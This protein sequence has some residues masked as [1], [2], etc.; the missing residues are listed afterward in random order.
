MACRRTDTYTCSSYVAAKSKEFDLTRF[1]ALRLYKRK[2]RYFFLFKNIT[3]V[4]YS[5]YARYND[6][7]F[8]T[9]LR[10]LLSIYEKLIEKGFHLSTYS[11]IAAGTL[12][13]SGDTTKH[14]IDKTMQLF[15]RIGSLVNFLFFKQ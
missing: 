8:K 10:E 2:S 13:N 15:K 4:Y 12:I 6:I 9:S 11:Y 14:Y 3:T 5:L 1:M 7:K